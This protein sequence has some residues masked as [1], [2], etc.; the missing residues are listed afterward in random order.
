VANAIKTFA[1]TESSILM[2]QQHPLI[3][4]PVEHGLSELIISRGRTGYL[5]LYRFDEHKNCSLILAIRHQH[6]AG[7][8]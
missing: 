4:H 2:L 7:Y 3:G 8:N 6:E 1:L 5:A